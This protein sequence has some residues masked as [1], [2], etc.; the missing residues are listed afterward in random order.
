MRNVIERLNY[1]FYVNHSARFEKELSEAIAKAPPPCR[2]TA[3]FVNLS[4]APKS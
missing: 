1:P 3:L 2:R 4:G